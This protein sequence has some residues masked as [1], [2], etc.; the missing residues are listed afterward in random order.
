MPDDEVVWVLPGLVGATVR[1]ADGGRDLRLEG[2][3]AL[4]AIQRLILGRRGALGAQA[5]G[6]PDVDRGRSAFASA[7]ATVYVGGALHEKVFDTNNALL[8]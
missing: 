8:A 5:L 4:A 3:A 6:G 7:G 1:A 2:V